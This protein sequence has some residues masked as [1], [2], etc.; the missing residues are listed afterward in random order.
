[1]ELV[2]QI[3][4]RAGTYDEY[5]TSVESWSLLSGQLHPPLNSHVQKN[6]TT[7]VFEAA[8]DSIQRIANFQSQSRFSAYQGKLSGCWLQALP[9][10]NLGLKL[11]DMQLRVSVALR[12]GSKLCE[13][14]ECICCTQVEENGLHGLSCRKS[15]GRFSRHSLLNDIVRRT[16]GSVHIPALLE[17]PGLCR[18]DGKRS[19]GM[20]TVPWNRGRPM[21]WDVTVGK[22]QSTR[23]L[24]AVATIFNLWRSR[25]RVGAA[26]TRHSSSRSWEESCE[27]R[28]T[29]PGQQLF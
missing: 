20:T 2:N 26:R 21:V 17:P 28:R 12:L 29:S 13:P 1:V 22:P 9:S 16:L 3:S 14:H 8:R 5:D 27:T 10:S 19:D 18:T 25:Y 11:T 23:Q 6:W 24:Q 15:A 7:L 4:P